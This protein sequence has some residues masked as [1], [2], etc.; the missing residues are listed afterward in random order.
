MDELNI[1]SEGTGNANTSPDPSTPTPV[2]PTP[3]TSPTNEAT[4]IPTPPSFSLDS[5]GS[6]NTPSSAPKLEVAQPT[7]EPEK[8][9]PGD[10]SLSGAATVGT[11]GAVAGEVA[12]KSFL[13]TG[14]IIAGILVVVGAAGA[15]MYFGNGGWP[16]KG[17][18]AVN[19]VTRFAAPTLCPDDQYQ[20]QQ[21]SQTDL[22]LLKG[23]LPVANAQ[24]ATPTT[25]TRTTTTRIAPTSMTLMEVAPSPT[26]VITNSTS[27][28]TMETSTATMQKMAP[29]QYTMEM[30]AATTQKL[31]PQYTMQMTTSTMQ[32]M[33]PLEMATMQVAPNNYATMELA[34]PATFAPVETATMQTAEP[35]STCKDIPHDNLTPGGDECRLVDS[36]YADPS[37]Y[38]LND[39]TK[40][41][42]NDWYTKCHPAPVPT[43]CPDD[44]YKPAGSTSTTSPQNSLTLLKGS[45]PMANAQSA[46]A[47]TPPSPTEGTL[48][49]APT[50]TTPLRINPAARIACVDIPH[51]DLTPGGDECNLV[52]QIYKDPSNYSIN[53]VTKGHLD[54]WYK[55]CHAT[56]QCG[57]NSTYDKTQNTC[58]CKEGYFDPSKDLP[59]NSITDLALADTTDKTLLYADVAPS[60][61]PTESTDAV[62]TR[63]TIDSV[64]T[65]NTVNRTRC[66]NC[67]DLNRMI[68]DYQTRL[69]NTTDTT[70]KA[71]LQKR[72]DLLNEIAIKHGCKKPEVKCVDGQTANANGI[73]ECPANTNFNETTQKCE[74]DCDRVVNAIV[75]MRNSPTQTPETEKQLSGLED[76]AAKNQCEVPPQKT[77]CQQYQEDAQKALSEKNYDAYINSSM[78]L[79]SADCNRNV[80]TCQRILAEASLTKRVANMDAS[81]SKSYMDRY[82][83]LRDQYYNTPE[84]KDDNRCKEIEAAMNGTATEL[85]P[86]ALENMDMLMVDTVSSDY[87]LN[88]NNL[89]TAPT[90]N[91]TPS[92]VFEDDKQYYDENCKPPTRTQ[93][94]IPETP[95]LS[96]TGNPP[97]VKPGQTVTWTAKIDGVANDS[98]AT[99]TWSKDAA[100]TGKSV[101]A[102]YNTSGTKTAIVIATMPD[103]PN[104]RATC[105]VKVADLAPSAPPP[106]A[107]PPLAPPPPPPTPNPPPPAPIITP[108]TPSPT[109]ATSPT[110]PPAPV[111]S[112]TPPPS[113]PVSLPIK[114]PPPPPTA[115]AVVPPPPPA[116]VSSPTPPPSAPVSLPITPSAPVIA[117]A[118]PA[119]PVVHPAAPQAVPQTVQ[120]ITP[121]GPE[122]YLYLIGFIGIQLYYFR[123][124]IYAYV[125]KK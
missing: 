93:E 124:Q 119:A 62:L 87:R 54:G 71:T 81:V 83:K 78:K 30:T 36:L 88:Q 27:T 85:T 79:L 116:P 90:M 14:L 66:M 24:T 1:K 65:D 72:L 4:N 103:Q 46:A 7:S 45:L 47:P 69:S 105:D 86:V 37:T 53:D 74:F 22:T 56:P 120:T 107:S 51:D 100:G 109:P 91:F 67:D 34:P 125:M 33:A 96:C 8:A 63:N 35:Q 42:L 31:A 39:V 9:A 89:E 76:L 123:R 122:V 43:L 97:S 11:S 60:P 26:A 49:L 2:T 110:P 20:P 29:Q 104:L 5:I 12:K 113:A 94:L 114:T 48:K 17:Q 68:L 111:S 18:L 16:F 40:D 108:P 52:D 50:E 75:S 19:E 82:N 15:A 77:T 115:P 55:I 3:P 61:T 98:T 59:A 10:S 101:T 13:K 32:K 112:P 6:M 25:T 84:C 28:Y 117:P 106:P 58:V 70:Q 41:H 57:T 23:S 95:V 44:Q 121:T 21:A 102:T 38:L 118:P 73:C 64:Y 80:D 99:Y 92:D